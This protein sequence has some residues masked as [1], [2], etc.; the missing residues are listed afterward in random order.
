MQNH[1]LNKLVISRLWSGEAADPS[2]I[3][4][5]EFRIEPDALMVRVDAPFHDDPPPAAPAGSTDRLWDYEVVELFL[6][7]DDSAY[8]EIELGP[9]G[10]YLVLQLKGERQL[11]KKGLAIAYKTE[12]E[13]SR[14]RG[15]ARIPLSCL[16]PGIIRANAYAIHGRDEGRRYLAAFPV[17]GKTPD[18]HRLSA[19]QKIRL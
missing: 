17:H 13:G 5:V 15:D 18:F 14:W 19:F 4:M 10:H 7:G 8:L 12:T 1:P 3:A 9:H 11:V 6:L 2:D 16:P